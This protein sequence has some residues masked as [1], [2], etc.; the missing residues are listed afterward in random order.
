MNTSKLRCPRAWQKVVAGGG[1]GGGEA[2]R[3]AIALITA[4][5]LA[6]EEQHRRGKIPVA[7]RPS[8]KKQVAPVV[9]TQTAEA[10]VAQSPELET[11]RAQAPDVAVATSILTNTVQSRNFWGG[12]LAAS[13]RLMKAGIITLGRLG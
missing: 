2:A 6:K 8:K 12:V 1:T 4:R 7:I 13:A 10:I 9:I 3:R 5:R 11:T